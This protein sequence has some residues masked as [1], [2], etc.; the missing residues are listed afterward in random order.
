MAAVCSQK[1]LGLIKWL[2]KKIKTVSVS[3]KGTYDIQEAAG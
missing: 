1:P 3:L 2:S